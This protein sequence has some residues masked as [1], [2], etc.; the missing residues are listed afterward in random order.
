MSSKEKILYQNKWVSLVERYN[1]ESGDTYTV[2]KE[3]DKV[4]ILPYFIAN[5]EL[6]IVYLLEPIS[7][8]SGKLPEITCISGTIEKKED[9]FNTA[10]R[11]LEEETGIIQKNESMWEYVGGFYH[12]KS[13][14]SKRHL[15][16]VDIT[17]SDLVKKSTDGSWFE[18]NTQNVVSRISKSLKSK[19]N[20]L[21]FAYLLNYLE[22]K[23]ELYEKKT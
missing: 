18:K 12:S 7:T 8:W 1:P 11:E 19:N 4:I 23:N 14:T 10:I 20:D 15:Y 21:Y 6:Y 17:D 9:F 22:T 3:A 2:F 16:V 13:A 5:N